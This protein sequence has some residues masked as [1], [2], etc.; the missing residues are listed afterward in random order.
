MTTLINILR[1]VAF[2]GAFTF[3]LAYHI[4][5]PWWRTEI[6]RNIMTFTLSVAALLLVAVLQVVF[7]PGWWFE[8]A[9]LLAMVGLSA[10]VWWRL[11]MFLRV[12]LRG[13]ERRH[14]AGIK[15]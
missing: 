13:E 8:T 3:A 11:V 12:Q 5:A 4:W 15:P 14:D 10:A 1:V 7:G 2:F 6:G 9:R